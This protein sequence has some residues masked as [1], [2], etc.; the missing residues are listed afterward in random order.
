MKKNFLIAAAFL[1]LFVS[2]CKKGNDDVPAN[3]PPAGQLLKKITRTVENTVTIFNLTYDAQK[4][5]QSVISTDNKEKTLF[6]YDAAGKLVKVEETEDGYRNVYTYT[7]ANGIPVSGTFKNWIL[8][9]GEPDELSEDDELTYTV[10]GGQVT[11][12]HLNMK[13]IEEEVDFDLAYT[14][15]NLTKVKSVGS[16]WYEAIFTFGNRKPIFPIV[17]DF[18]LDHAG[19]SLQY[20]AKN[21]ILS[22]KFDF[23]GTELDEEQINQITYD[24]NGY[25][26]TANDGTAQLKF[27]Y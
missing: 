11:R 21:D 18:V 8:V 24:A 16:N 9:A 3:T 22:M 10:T 23:P 14:N 25:A 13:M 27:E 2:S 15:G 6:T 4:R 5:L 7:Y 17:L 12:I 20:A 26:L 1:A 19:F